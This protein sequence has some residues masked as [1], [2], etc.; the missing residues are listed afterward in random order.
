MGVWRRF[1]G[2]F[3]AGYV[4][5]ECFDDE[6]EGKDEKGMRYPPRWRRSDE[7][8]RLLRCLPFSVYVFD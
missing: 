8:G 3:E 6:K 2:I 4:V 1:A 7:G 5:S